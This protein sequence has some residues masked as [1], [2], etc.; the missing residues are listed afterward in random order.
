MNDPRALR[1]IQLS[2]M[3]LRAEPGALL[4]G[5]DPEAGLRKVLSVI[6]QGEA[7]NLFLLTGDL[8]EDPVTEAYERVRDLVGNTGVPAWCLPGNHDD[9]DLMRAE[10]NRD[11]LATPRARRADGWLIMLLDSTLPGQAGGEL[12]H[13][14]LATLADTLASYPDEPALVALHHPPVAL[15]SRWID[16]LGL[17][18]AGA[19]FDVIDANPQVRAVIWGHAHQA[20]EGRW[21]DTLLLGTPSTTVQFKPGADA[22]AIDA[23]PPGWR[24]LSLYP[25]GRIETHVAWLDDDG[26]QACP[27]DDSGNE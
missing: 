6:G 4:R 27:P 26:R 7:P 23:R 5:G 13:G 10:L 8:V 21:E 1:V 16:E 3:H 17:G 20:W 12:G 2:D 9:P 14:E 18:D 15:G 11:G 25:D 22:F 19:F 24:E